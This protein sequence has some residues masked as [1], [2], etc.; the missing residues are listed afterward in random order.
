MKANS[1]AS[2]L[3]NVGSNIG[4]MNAEDVEKLYQ[5]LLVES[6]SNPGNAEA[7]NN[8]LWKS[9]KPTPG[10][11][12]KTKNV[13]T[14]EKVFLNICTSSTVPNPASISEEEL[15]KMLNSLDDPD[16]IVDYRIPMSVGAAHAE[17]DNRGNGCTAYDIIISPNFLHTITNSKIFLGFFMSV[18]FEAVQTKYEVELERNWIMLKGK[19]FLGKLDEQNVR[20]QKLIQEVQPSNTPLISEMPSAKRPRIDIVGEPEENPDFLIAEINLPEISSAKSIIL[21]VGEDRLVLCTRPKLYELDIYLPYN[22]IQEECGSQF[23][24]RS[25]IL[26]ITMPISK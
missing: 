7:G 4:D 23:D 22:L 20:T 25:H 6:Q 1:D 21:D 8:P 15:L 16:Q 14:K 12:I 19:K 10:R 18:V 5:E 9:V 3:F 2:E 17:L 11:C 26:T 13:K 24:I